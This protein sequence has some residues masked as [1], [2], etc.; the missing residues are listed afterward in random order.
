MAIQMLLTASGSLEPL[1][2]D[3]QLRTHPHLSTLQQHLSCNS[4]P[5]FTELLST[6]ARAAEEP[7]RRLLRLTC[8]CA[9]HG[10]VR[11]EAVH[12]R[13]PQQLMGHTSVKAWL[14]VLVVCK[15]QTGQTS[16]YLADEICISDPTSNSCI[17]DGLTKLQFSQ[18]AA[19][20]SQCC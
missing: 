17:S 8:R 16:S 1:Y 6:W 10:I 3:A 9:A 14:A 18:P 4:T 20:G 2:Y 15:G 5:A 11:F 13:C 7:I 19:K 12:T